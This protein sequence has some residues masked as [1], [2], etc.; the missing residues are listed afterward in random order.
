MDEPSGTVAENSDKTIHL[1]FDATNM[2]AE[3]SKFTLSLAHDGQNMASPL[4]IPVQ[5]NVRG[6]RRL[7][8]SPASLDFGDVREDGHRSLSILLVNTGFEKTTIQDIILDNPEFRTYQSMP[9]EIA[10]N[11]SYSLSVDFSPVGT[12]PKSG[13]ITFITDADD[14]PGPVVTVTGNGVLPPAVEVN[15]ASFTEILSTN[16]TITRDLVITN[17]GEYP[18]YYSLSREN[19]AGTVGADIYGHIWSDS[20]AASDPVTFVWEDIKTTGTVLD[21]SN[22]SNR[23]ANVDIP[24]EF[25]FYGGKYTRLYVCTNGY[26]FLTSNSNAEGMNYELPSTNGKQNMIAPFWDDLNPGEQG[27][28]FVESG[29]DRVIIQYNNVKRFSSASNLTFQI[30]LKANGEIFFYYKEMSGTGLDSATVG[31]QN[32][33]RDDGFSIVYNTDFTCSEYAVRISPPG[34]WLTYD[35]NYED[36]QQVRLDPGMSETIS[37]TFDTYDFSPGLKETSLLLNHNGVNAADPLLIPVQL[38]V[39]GISS[40]TA[41]VNPLDF[42]R[43]ITG[44]NFRKTISL[45]N[46]GYYPTTVLDLTCDPADFTFTTAE[47][48][49]FVIPA[50]SSIPVEIT[51]QPGSTGIKT[52]VLAVTSEAQDNSLLNITLSGEGITIP[53]NKVHFYEDFEEPLD[54]CWTASLLRG[55]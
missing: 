2:V 7:S 42:G 31:I 54:T 41:S 4:E 5:M 35:L 15:Q 39:I 10:P 51:F 38:D 26:I 27:E 17:S 34:S 11:G 6:T 21:I 25:P 20:D 18:L 53:Q 29:P 45:I 43:I 12:G 37:L 16:R 28:I 50:G 24:F 48:L 47:P 52:G 46:N 14:N 23:I 55:F 40:I 9:V 19:P 36:Y 1:T 49:P 30:V 8:L 3:T 22:Q 33:N 44:E 32:Y 13:N